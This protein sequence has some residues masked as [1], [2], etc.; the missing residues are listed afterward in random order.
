MGNA[1]VDVISH[2]DDQFLNTHGM[3]KGWMDL[4]DTERAV[5][6][7]GSAAFGI[8]NL[9]RESARQQAEGRFNAFFT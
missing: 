1:L 4:I 5:A 6:I 9:N 2:V 8:D 3:V 7:A